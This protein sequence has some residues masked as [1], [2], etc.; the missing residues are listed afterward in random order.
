MCEQTKPYF[1]ATWVSGALARELED[2]LR[3]A[4]AER[5]KAIAAFERQR[6]EVTRLINENN[7]LR[8]RDAARAG[9]Y[10]QEAQRRQQQADQK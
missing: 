10:G 8:V 1:T 2:A 9:F 7:R 4:I 3:S 5:D 6:N